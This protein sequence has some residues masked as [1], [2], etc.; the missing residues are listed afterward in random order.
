MDNVKLF[1]TD[2]PVAESTTVQVGDLEAVYADGA[3]RN[4][5][6]RGVE[7]LRG[8]AWLSRDKD[9]NTYTPEIEN[10]SLQQ[11][12]G[13]FLITYDCRVADSEQS[14][15]AAVRIAG[16]ESELSF[17]VRCTAETD[18]VTNRTGLV[19]LHPLDGV[20]G[21]PVKVVHTD[22][23]KATLSFPDLISPGQPIFEI[24]SLA[25]SVM[26]GIEASVCFEGS[27][28]EMEDH[29]NWMDA[30]YKT[31]SG[32]LLDPW[33]YTVPAG[34][35]FSQSIGLAITGRPPEARAAQREGGVCV[36]IGAEAGRM[37]VFG[38]SATRA[39]AGIA[40]EKSDL[41]VSAGP[42]YLVCRVD[43]RL[44]DLAKTAELYARVRRRTEIPATAEIILPARKPAESE[45]AMIAGSLQSGGFQPDAVVVTQAHDLMSFQPGAHRPW[46]PSYSEMAAAARSAFP[47]V[48]VGGGM[49]SFFTELNRK[50][51][52]RGVFDFIT[53]A[54]CPLVHAADDR[55]AMENLEAFSWI[56][57]S[58]RGM[59]GDSPYHIGP[60]GLACA[61]NPYADGVVENRGNERACLAD[62]DPRH[63]GLFGAAWLLGFASA[64]AYSGLDAVALASAT[65]K[66]GFIYSRADYP[67]PGFD[68]SD[69]VLFPAYH[70]LAGLTALSGMDLVA[71]DCSHP[72][73]VSV[74]ASRYGLSTVLWLANLTADRQRVS[75]DGL[76]GQVHRVDI[77]EDS[78]DDA[79]RY[80]NHLDRASITERSLSGLELGP[81][82]VVRLET[83]D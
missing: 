13:S 42:A 57:R 68:D 3:I 26:P 33:P 71:A 18:F 36:K 51:P 62:M 37:P 31:Y 77:D 61:D 47:N 11:D 53:H 8:I 24:R 16:G 19:L 10:L 65:G 64:C 2:A 15:L 25:H 9:W 17:E 38:T 1:G 74:L 35:R 12:S 63:R 56:A 50:V 22:G 69:A 40:V 39:D 48:P 75:I 79:T 67:Q 60:S 81:Y 5:K 82:A 49:L 28:F 21:R 54:V 43:G 23:S 7:V 66:R 46:G 78:F 59:I 6:Y 55:F 80:A 83:A 14:L 29:R 73:D 30:S 20:A 44:P 72:A 34:K 41:I 58:V 76:E 32:S 27:K 45:M 52:P 4:V 70:V